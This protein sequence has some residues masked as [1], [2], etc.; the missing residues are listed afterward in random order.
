G[1]VA[2]V[3]PEPEAAPIEAQG[4]GWL[5]KHGS[6]KAGDTITSGLEVTWTSTPTKWTNN[7]FW[8][9]FGYEWELETSPAGAKQWVPKHGMGANSVPDAHDPNKR[10]A[11]KMLT[12]DMALRLDPT[13]EKISRRFYENP[14]VFAD[15]FAKAWFKL[16]HR[17]M[18][19]ISRYLGPEIPKV[20]FIWQDIIPVNQHELI[21]KD[22]IGALKELILQSGLSIGEM[23]STAWASASTFRISDKRGGANGA[24]VKLEPQ[25]NWVV[26]NPTQLTKVIS[27]LEAIQSKFNQSNKKVSIADLIVLAGGTAIE[28]AAKDAGYSVIVPFMPGRA[29][30]TMEQT[31]I[32]SI[33]VLEPFADG[34]RNYLKSKSTIATE[35]LLIDKAQL[36]NL[37]APEL[38]VL[39]GGMR[40]LNTNYDGS[41]HGVFT[42]TPERLTNDFFVNLLNINTVWKAIDNTE[43]I[44]EGTDRTTGTKKYTATRN[45][46][47]FGSNSELRALAEVYASEDAKEK[48]VNDF[49]TA[50]T[51]VMNLDR[52]DLKNKS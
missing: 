24:R 39:I 2:L 4:L 18:G 32:D 25:K 14:D 50:W 21:S 31:E 10:H 36:L 1:D 29:D 3:G 28:K 51:K 38:T 46:L 52:F 6:G 20:E 26:N 5:S 35:E 48:F 45:D 17:D 42:S 23:V 13:Y 40:M 16:T 41:N 7:F 30:A 49:V 15:A 34:F 27:T 11:P 8:N 37:N 9:L 19:P 47:I 44:F 12:T 43:E 33:A 22:D